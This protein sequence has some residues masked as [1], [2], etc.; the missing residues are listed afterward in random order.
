MK[1]L[2]FILAVLAFA[3]GGPQSRESRPAPGEEP[4][5]TA[6]LGDE[7]VVPLEPEAA[8]PRAPASERPCSWAKAWSDPA[9]P[10]PLLA[11]VGGT[12]IPERAAASPVRLSVREPSPRGEISVEIVVLPDGS[13]SEATV[14]STT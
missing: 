11:G 8:I 3:C 5:E 6:S 2:R 9:T 10:D 7:E 12:P 4:I 14:V 1:A 13:V